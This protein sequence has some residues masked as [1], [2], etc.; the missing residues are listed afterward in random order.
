MKST[1]ISKKEVARILN[2]SSSSVTRWSK[3]NTDFP[4]PFLLGPNKVVWDLRE[5]E[6]YINEQKKIRGFL[7]HRPIK[8]VHDVNK[9]Q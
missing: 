4:K 2:I 6:H 9:T 1:Y 7:G 3:E 5:I 8:L